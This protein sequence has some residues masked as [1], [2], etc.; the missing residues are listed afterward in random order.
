MD[1]QRQHEEDLGIR[2]LHLAAESEQDMGQRFAADSGQD[3]GQRI[4]AA[5][6][7]DA[8]KRPAADP[9]EQLFTRIGCARLALAKSSASSTNQ[10]AAVRQALDNAS[11]ELQQGS[12]DQRARL[13]QLLMQCNFEEEEEEKR[14][15]VEALEALAPKRPDRRPNQV[16]YP[17]ILNYFTEFEWTGMNGQG[18]TDAMGLL[19]ARML[20]LGG[21]NISEKCKTSLLRVLL[22]LC[23][24]RGL[25]ESAKNEMLQVMKSTYK[26]QA[27]RNPRVSQ[28]YLLVLPSPESLKTLHPGLYSSVFP[29]GDPRPHDPHLLEDMPTVV[30][31]R[32]RSASQLFRLEAARRMDT[33]QNLLQQVVSLQGASMIALQRRDDSNT[34]FMGALRNLATPP[35]S[36]SFH[37]D[38]MGGERSIGAHSSFHVPQSPTVEPL[39][40]SNG[41]PHSPANSSHASQGSGY[42]SATDETQAW[43][44]PLD[45]CGATSSEVVGSLPT[46]LDGLPTNMQ[47]ST[48]AGE[49]EPIATAAA[50]GGASLDQRLAADTALVAA[51]TTDSTAAVAPSG[52]KGP[53]HVTEKLLAPL[54]SGSKPGAQDRRLVGV[55][56]RKKEPAGEPKAASKKNT[57]LKPSHHHRSRLNPIVRHPTLRS[58]KQKPLALQT[59]RRRFHT[60][61]RDTL[62]G[63]AFLTKPAKASCTLKAMQ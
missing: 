58:P 12:A 2:G 23:D 51:E 63:C 29:D 9:L 41:E 20:Q 56:K 57:R 16:F 15:L 27:R 11:K 48:R 21:V 59:L 30:C 14:Q 10:A 3:V 22:K 28:V 60:K 49:A 19:I 31:R 18:V 5:P 35:R 33:T 52:A 45:G 47:V 4:A 1:L 32:S 24:A 13:H 8:G 46:K 55:K 42:A 40:I 6:G 62:I 43:Q 50:D 54:L 44:Q 7:N 26:N 17:S 34:N 37:Q 39:A 25:A 36:P 61:N 53:Q 38:L